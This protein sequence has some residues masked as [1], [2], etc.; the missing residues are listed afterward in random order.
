MQQWRKDN[1]DKLRASAKAWRLANPERIKEIKRNWRL[2]NLEKVKAQAKASC[3][4]NA[5]SIRDR[6]SK[7]QRANPD[8]CSVWR[9]RCYA[10]NPEPFIEAARKRAG[11]IKDQGEKLSRGLAKR[12]IVAQNFKCVLCPADLRVSGYHRDHIVALANGGRHE[13]A[14]IQ[15]LC[16]TCNLRKGTK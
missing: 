4:R 15:L 6:N 3:K 1:R 14:N 16:P 11:R 12:M 8:K 7:Y 10:K 13:D 5:A 2:R 9:K